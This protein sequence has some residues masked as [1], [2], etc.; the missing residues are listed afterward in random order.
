MFLI[1]R[2]R[3]QANTTVPFRFTLVWSHAI[4]KNSIGINTGGARS[5]EELP[6]QKGRG[7]RHNRPGQR[8]CEVIRRPSK[9]CCDAQGA[10]L[11]SVVR[12]SA[13]SAGAVVP[14]G[15]LSPRGDLAARSAEHSSCLR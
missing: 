10:L 11:G 15:R 5:A 7:P 12:P 1:G 4:V 9:Q 14:V 3:S 8:A 13:Q 6:R 2:H